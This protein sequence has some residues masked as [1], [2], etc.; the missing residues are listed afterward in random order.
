MNCYEL[1]GNI[2]NYGSTLIRINEEEPVKVDVAADLRNNGY[3]FGVPYYSG[4]E[5]RYS[6]DGCDYI[7][8][9][10]ELPDDG[11]PKSVEIYLE[12]NPEDVP[13]EGH[14][15]NIGGICERYDEGARWIWDDEGAS[16]KYLMTALEEVLESAGLDPETIIE[17]GL[18]RD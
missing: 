17:D 10:I 4:G 8:V 18:I 3:K 16:E 11:E 15:E 12:C 1:V 9:Y 14:Y 2:R 13:G 7:L 5:S 6:R